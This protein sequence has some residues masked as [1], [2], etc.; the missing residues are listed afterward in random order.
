M[1]PAPRRR[2]SSSTASSTSSATRTT[3]G[4]VWP[5]PMRCRTRSSSPGEPTCRPTWSHGSASSNGA[6][7]STAAMTSRTC[8]SQILPQSRPGTP[9]GRAGR[10]SS[11]AV[12]TRRMATPADTA[13]SSG[14]RSAGRGREP[15]PQPLAGRPRARARHHAHARRRHGH[16]DH[17][18]GDHPPGGRLRGLGLLG[19]ERLQPRAHGALPAHGPARRPLR[20]QARLHARPRAVHRRLAAV[21]PRDERPHA[22][23]LAR[24][25]GGRRRGRRAHGARPAPAGVP[26]ASPGLRRRPVRGRQLARPRGRPRARRRARL[27][28]GLAGRLLAQ[29]P[30]RDRR[31]RPRAHAHARP[32]HA[33]HP[34]VPR[35][36]RRRP[37]QRRPLLRHAGDH[38]GQRLGLDV[39]RRHRPLRRRRRPAPPLGVVG[40]PHRLSPLRPPPVPRPHLRRVGHGR[41]DR[42]HRD[43]G[44]DVHGRDLHDRDDGL[45]RAQGRARDRHPPGRRHDPDAAGRLA[46][47]PHRTALARGDRRAGDRR[48]A[49]RPRAPRA[50]RP[51]ERRASGGAPSSAPASGSRCRR[52]SPP[53]W[54]PCP[55]ATRA[56][57]PG[58]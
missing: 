16:D 26:R 3:G 28:Q 5:S 14:R 47:R 11:A 38:P 2:A 6:R 54:A 34:R 9:S 52:C 25:A 58:C 27:V 57:A 31:R 40:A 10:P 49:L 30:G 1:T 35:L 33:A 42:G 12:Y 22:G 29:P 37:R 56:P 43:D 4:T 36:A 53:G 20:P 41:H 32:A 46:R 39:G 15:G 19:D 21:R 8:M 7:R 17:R 45:Q 23:R 51:G 24:G 50:H 44:H 18:A 13:R 48:R 55:A